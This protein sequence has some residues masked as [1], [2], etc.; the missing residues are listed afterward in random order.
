MKEFYDNK[1]FLA[2]LHQIQD[3]IALIGEF[4][5]NMTKEEF[6]ADKKTFLAVL[7]EFWILDSV[8]NSIKTTNI[9]T[10]ITYGCDFP[11][12]AYHQIKPERVWAA[13]QEDIPRLKEQI[14]KAIDTLGK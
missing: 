3:E 5:D 13:V 8:I 1:R 10:E 4:T 6:E 7:C 14:S 11:L 12:H 9:S 2:L